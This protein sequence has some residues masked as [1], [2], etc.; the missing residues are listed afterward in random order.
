[1][2]DQKKMPPWEVRY[3]THRDRTALV[4]SEGWMGPFRNLWPISPINSWCMDDRHFIPSKTA[5]STAEQDQ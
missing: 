3:L 2:L 5:A 4:R 1:V